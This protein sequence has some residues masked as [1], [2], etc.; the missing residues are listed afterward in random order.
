MKT[1]LPLLAALTLGALPA[2]AQTKTEAAAADERDAPLA[3]PRLTLAGWGEL[4]D[5]DGDCVFE[6]K[7]ATLTITVP[8]TPKPHD[9]SAELISMN[10]PRVLQPVTGDFTIEVRVDGEF[11]PGDE[12]TQAGRTGY[13]GAGL[14]LFADSRNFVRIERATLQR[15]NQE[16][17]GYVNFEIRVDGEVIRIGT[18]GDRPIKVDQPVFLRLVRT[19]DTLHGFA[20]DDGEKW[21]ELDPKPIPTEWPKDLQ[22]G[23]AAISTSK[24]SF[25]PVFSGL[26]LEVP[27]PSPTK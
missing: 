22:A 25:T 23:V 2:T 20:S 26:K 11:K 3:T 14:L 21:D 15:S 8:G 16:P 7:D 4:V 19:G 9:L 18:T 12:S 17:S 24:V 5:P 6:K 27:R 1:L 13:N 10:A